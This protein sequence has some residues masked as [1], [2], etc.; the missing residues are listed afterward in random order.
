MLHVAKDTVVHTMGIAELHNDEMEESHE[1]KKWIEA[2]CNF[3]ADQAMEQ[4]DA[5]CL[6][7]LRV[8]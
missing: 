2:G 3:K 8:A 4:V 5:S 6:E 7:L 1:Y